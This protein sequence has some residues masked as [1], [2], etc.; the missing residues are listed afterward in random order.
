MGVTVVKKK[1]PANDAQA[2]LQGQGKQL[3]NTPANVAAGGG[4][5][6]QRYQQVPTHRWQGFLY[7][8][9]LCKALL[10]VRVYACL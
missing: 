2:V 10:E 3:I 6:C 7:V 5:G 1:M 9:W 8:R 4:A